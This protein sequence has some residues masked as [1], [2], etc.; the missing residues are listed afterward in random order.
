MTATLIAAEVDPAQSTSE[1]MQTAMGV[2]DEMF[3]WKGLPRKG[4][5]LMIFTVGQAGTCNLLTNGV[6]KRSMAALLRET[7][8]R[9]E[10]KEP[11]G[12]G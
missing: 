9:L 2:L 3:Q 10:G 6:E 7:A 8:D 4:I 5:A 1:V 11:H 12:D